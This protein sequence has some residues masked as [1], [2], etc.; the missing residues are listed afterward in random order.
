MRIIKPK[1]M[2]TLYAFFLM[3]FITTT[4][5]QAQ[6]PLATGNISGTITDENKKNL[7][8][9]TVALFHLPDSTLIKT[10]LTDPQGR[11]QFNQI[12]AG[13]YYLKANMM[14]YSLLTSK[15]FVLDNTHQN[16]SLNDLQIISTSKALNEVSV[17]ATK[18]LLERKLDK[19][20]MN[21]EGSSV[22]TGSSALEVL[23][24]APGVSVDQNDQISM[25]GKQGV[26]I[27][28]DGKQ[29][30]MSSAD[31]TSMLRNMQS[32]QI[33]S[34]ELITN[35]S[36]KYEAAGNSG[37]I[38]I[39]TKKQQNAGTNG[40]IILGAAQGR[41]FR[42]NTG[43]NL[44]HRAEHFNIYGNYNYGVV[45][46]FQETSIDRISTLGTTNTYFNQTGNSITRNYNNNFKA[47]I[48]IFLNK[49]NTLGFMFNGYLNNE[50]QN[51]ENQTFI[52]SAAGK[53]DSALF[54]NNDF[55]NKYQ[56]LSYNLNYKAVLDTTG[57]ELTA[58][59]D[60]SKYYGNQDAS[61]VNNHLYPDGSPLRPTS[62]MN[63]QSPSHID[64]KALKADYT[65]PLSTSLK[66]ETGVK[67]SWV[68]TDNNFIFQDEFNGAGSNRFIYKEDI[69]AGYFNLSK[70]Y[71]NTN[72]QIG[73]RAEQ[74]SSL[75]NSVNKDKINK[76][77]YLNLFPT[78]FVNQKLSE[79]HSIGFSYGRR[80]DRPSY[81]AL[82]P[83]IFYLDQYT[84]NQG[85][86]FLKPQYT[87]NFEFNYTFLQ[88]YTLTLNYSYVHDAIIEV[89]L[90]D[91]VK[92]AL[93]QTSVNVDKNTS[94]SANLNVPVA[95]TKWWQ[96]NNNLNVFH[97]NFQQADLSGQDLNTG[98]TSFQFK[99]QHSFIIRKD[100][101]AE[102]IGSYESPLV[103]G[104]LNLKARYG[105][106][107]GLSKSFM[108]KKMNVKL[109]LS[110]VFNTQI[111]K[112]SSAYPGLKYNLNQKNESQVGRITLTYRFGK[113]EIKPARKR[114]TGVEEETGRMKN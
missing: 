102:L 4:I 10:A 5:S 34:I 66:L 97:L 49:N 104:T 72:I 3:L 110:D 57:Q 65:L 95:I 67:G 100:L 17:V 94:Y 89:L 91:N 52:G 37:I 43:I 70:E 92:K 86:E 29:T 63:N 62:Y 24:K 68:K 25:Q 48:D 103:Y 19:L 22:M 60:Y 38:N 42:G 26:M 69:Y 74:T 80:I 47:G 32:S 105:I 58:D 79:Q 15:A 21:V 98:K 55:K 7:D 96:T 111:T 109:A 99:S 6:T 61:Y 44:N 45:K 18:P 107:M 87:D 78:M 82:N 84:Y 1:F 35:P 83:F 9:V 73:L 16:I 56:N 64:I 41:Y 20:V 50:K 88:K 75:G 46:R 27:Q 12:K 81:D 28:I 106:D 30:Y 39:K 53:V 11:F 113:N 85:N 14:G 93:Y 51:F 114:A 59:L 77:N 101:S 23:Q 13:A 112:L 2:K 40:S 71:K 108:D 90:P 8:Y 76:R 54:S 36:S 33:E 31:V